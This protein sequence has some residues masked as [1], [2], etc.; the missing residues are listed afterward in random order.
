MLKAMGLPLP[1]QLLVHGWWQKDGEKISKSTGN[2][3]DPVVVIGEWGL[4]AFRYYVT[5]ELDI[6]PD[7]NWTDSGFAARYGAELANGLGNLVNRS[8]SML[9]RY[10]NGIVPAV[11]NELQKDA[12]EFVT[13]VREHYEK[14]EVQDALTTTWSLITRANQYVDQTAPFKLA[15]DPAQAARL[16]EVLYNLAE[17]CRVIALLVAPVLPGTAGKIL[18]QLNLGSS[19]QTLAN[20]SWGG[21]VPGH[22]IGQPAALF[23]RKDTPQK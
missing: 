1:K 17:V 5:R 9:N 6:G 15:K 7:G 12:D 20:L 11:S 14:H 8:L 23:P 2:I 19:T 18:E 3:V 16:D 13:R 21:M 10:R 4:D 22:Q